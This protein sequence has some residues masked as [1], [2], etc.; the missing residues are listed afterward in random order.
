MHLSTNCMHWHPKLHYSLQFWMEVTW[1]ICST[2]E[3]WSTWE[4]LTRKPQKDQPSNVLCCNSTCFHGAC[5]ILKSI[6]IVQIP[7]IQYYWCESLRSMV[8]RVCT[9]IY[10][11]GLIPHT[12]KNAVAKTKSERENEIIWNCTI[13]ACINRQQRKP[14][15]TI[16]NPPRPT[17]RLKKINFAFFGSVTC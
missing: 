13:A 17:V 6:Q 1:I 7:M 9:P 14:Y 8:M 4:S 12:K 2:L 16:V 15:V 11:D 3:V 5:C 10:S